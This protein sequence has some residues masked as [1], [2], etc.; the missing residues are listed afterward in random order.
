MMNDV[1][2]APEAVGPENLPDLKAHVEVLL[3]EARAQGADAC[4]ALALRTAH[5][6]QPG[7]R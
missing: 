2:K 7:G 5:R 1:N 3:A 4:E 6:V